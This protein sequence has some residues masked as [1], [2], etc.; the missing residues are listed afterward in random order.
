MRLL[1]DRILDAQIRE[2]AEMKR[3]VA[4]LKATLANGPV[5]PSYR[6]RNAAPPETSAEAGVDTLAPQR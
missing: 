4:R 2:I 6:D 5:L 3:L 1:A